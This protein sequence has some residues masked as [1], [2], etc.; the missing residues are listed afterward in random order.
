M[1]EEKKKDLTATQSGRDVEPDLDLLENKIG[2]LKVQYEQYFLDIITQPPDKLFEEVVRL[3]KTLQNAPFKNSVTRFRLKT[4]T[5]R[6]QT[7][8]TYWEK[9]KKQ[10]EEGT[11]KRD[12]F[13]AKLRT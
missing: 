5:T 12:I 7:Y 6:F 8:K 2:E 9:V 1:A 13:K 3:I 11:Y 10:R 4:L